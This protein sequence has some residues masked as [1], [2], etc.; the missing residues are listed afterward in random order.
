MKMRENNEITGLKITVY[1]SFNDEVDSYR[2]HMWLCDG[3]CRKKPPFYGIVKRAKNMAPSERDDWCMQTT[4]Y[5]LFSSN[6][7]EV[8]RGHLQ[9]DRGA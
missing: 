1:H 8:V 5:T 4:F 6:S 9:Q 2:Q 3:P 7:S